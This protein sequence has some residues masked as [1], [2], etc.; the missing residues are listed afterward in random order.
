MENDQEQRPE[1]LLPYEK[2]METAMRQV[3]A[4]AMQHIAEN[5]FPGEHH[6]YITFRTGH[7]GAQMPEWLRRQYPETMRIHLRHNY[8]DLRVDPGATQFSVG[9][10]FSGTPCT[11]IV[12]FTSVTEFVDPF[13]GLALQLRSGEPEQAVEQ[14]AEPEK[15]QEAEPA[16]PKLAGTPQVVS[17][18]AFRRRTPTKE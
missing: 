16:P 4:Q 15:D 18:D 13:I 9:L 8:V 7:Q 6:F 2:W 11:L 14:E 10:S 12:P 17:L 3:V 5:G 1:S